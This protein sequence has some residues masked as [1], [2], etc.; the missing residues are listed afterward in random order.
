MSR[1]DFAANGWRLH[2]TKGFLGLV[3]PVWERIEEDGPVLAFQAEDKHRNLR[4]VVQ[5]GMLMT[6]ADRLL[7][8]FA[9]SHND[10]RPQA[11]IQLDVHF[12]APVHIGDVVLGRARMVRNTRSLMFVTGELTV[13]GKTVV[14]ASGVWKKLDS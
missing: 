1:Y 10:Q 12:L 3:G 6:V 8:A 7:G 13:D 9:R 5:G 2:D 4:D 11:T 14:T